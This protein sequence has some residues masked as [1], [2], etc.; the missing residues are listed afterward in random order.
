M[1]VDTD[2][3]CLTCFEMEDESF[4]YVPETENGQ[5]AMGRRFSEV[6]CNISGKTHLIGNEEDCLQ[7]MNR[8][9]DDIKKNAK[10]GQDNKNTN[11]KTLSEHILLFS[12]NV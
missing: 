9:S 5:T 4:L 2:T 10:S 6:H 8:F 12:Q 3:K 1:G 11:Q 7:W